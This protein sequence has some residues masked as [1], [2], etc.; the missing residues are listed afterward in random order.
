VACCE[1]VLDG[2]DCSTGEIVTT[3]SEKAWKFDSIPRFLFSCQPQFIGVLE[4]PFG[5]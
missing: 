1:I 3:G 5:F 4:N 2:I